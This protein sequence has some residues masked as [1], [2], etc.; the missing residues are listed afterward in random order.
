MA[1]GGSGT[2]FTTKTPPAFNAKH[3]DYIK[4]K[5]KLKL[6]QSV[7]EAYADTHG[8]LIILRLDDD[9]QDAVVEALGDT[10]LNVETGADLVIEK[11]DTIFEKDKTLSK[12]EIYEA[13]E[14][15]KRPSGMSVSDY[16]N[17]FERRLNKTKAIKMELSNDILAYRLLKSANLPQSTEHLIK[18]T[19]FDLEYGEMKT[20]MKKIFTKGSEKTELL[21]QDIKVESDT[22]YNENEEIFYGRSSAGK[23]KFRG[24]QQRPTNPAQRMENSG[25]KTY[26]SSDHFAGKAYTGT[27]KKHRNRL[28]AQGN[29]TR[30]NNCESINHYYNDCPD[31]KYER[32]K[33][34]RTYYQG[35]DMSSD[36][37]D[38]AREVHHKL[39]LFQD[40][41][42]DPGKLKT[43]VRESMSA[44]VLDCGAPITVCGQ[45]WLSCYLETLS[46][47]DKEKV[48]Y[49]TSTNKFKFGDSSSYA[50]E[51]QA[52]IPAVIG[53]KE[54]RIKTDIINSDI[55]LLLSMSSLIK[56]EANLDFPSGTIKILGQKIPLS[57]T[58]SGHYC[59]PLGKHKQIMTNA[60]RNPNV[61][62]TLNN[63]CNL[64]N[65]EIALKL[66]RQFS[67]CPPEKL[68]KLVRN[69]GKEC[70][71]LV[72]EIRSL[73][74]ACKICKEY[75]K[76]S[77]R[78]VVGLP[79]ATRFGECVAIDLKTYGKVHF[80]HLVD[81]ATRLSAGAIIRN[82]K[83]T[84]VIKELF[85]V[86]ISIY[87]TPEKLLTDNGGEFNNSEMRD[88]CERLN[89]RVK[90]TAAESAWSNGLV[91][92]HHAVIADMI[93]KIM[94]DINCTLEFALMWSLCAKNSLM[95]VNGFSPYQLV[96]SR[97]PS[98]PALL[99]DKPP[100][101][102]EQSQIEMIRENLNVLHAS[103]QAFI[104]SES[105]EKIKRALQHN[106]RRSGDVK[107]FTGDSVYYKRL[108]DRKWHGPA[109]VLGQD[110]QQVLVKHGGV[111]VRVHP[112]RL[113]LE[114]ERYQKPKVP[115]GDEKNKVKSKDKNKSQVI[116]SGDECD[117]EHL[118]SL[119][120]ESD[121]DNRKNNVQS[122]N[123]N[124]FQVTSS[125]EDSDDEYFTRSEEGSDSD[126]YD[127]SEEDEPRDRNPNDYDDR[128]S[129]MSEHSVTENENQQVQNN[130]N[131]Q[132]KNNENQQVQN[133][134]NQQVQN[135]EN[136]QVQNAENQQFD[137]RNDND[138]NH[139]GEDLTPKSIKNKLTLKK[140]M[141]VEYKLKNQ[142]QIH[143]GE[144]Y[145]RAGK[146]GGKYS[147]EWNVMKDGKNEVVNFDDAADLKLL[148]K[149]QW[150]HYL[151]QEYDTH[152]STS[153]DSEEDDKC[154]SETEDVFFNQTLITQS[155]N[156][157]LLAK[158]RELKSWRDN[159]VYTE[160]NR[161]SQKL[162]SVK[163]LIKPKLIDG[164]HSIKARLVAKGY[165][166]EQ[167]FR[168]DSPTCQ[169]PSIRLTLS[170]ISSYK[171]KLH[172]LDYKTAYLQGNPIKRVIYINPPKEANT[173]KIWKLN[174]TV[175][176]L[177]DAPREWY[178]RLREVLLAAGCKI[179]VSDSGLFFFRTSVLEGVIVTYV[180]D[181]VWGG[182]EKFAK[183][184][185][186]K[187]VNTFSISSENSTAFQ[188]IGINT[189][190]KKNMSIQIDQNHY[191]ASLKDIA[192]SESRRQQKHEPLTSL[193]QS[194]LKSM[195][196]KANWLATMTRP[197]I[198]F[199]VCF[200]GSS[201]EDATV[202]NI[203]CM[204]K[205]IRH[206]KATPVSIL[207]PNLDMKNIYLVVYSDASYKNLAKGGSQGAYIIFLS[208]G[209]RCCPIHWS[210]TRI[211]RV[212]KSTL[213][214]ETLA[215][216]E[217]CDTAFMLSKMISEIIGK[218]IEIKCIT[219]NQSLYETAHTSNTLTDKRL[220]FEI[221]SIREMIDKEEIKLSW[222]PAKEQ[223]SNVLTKTGV[224]GTQ[225]I[226][227]LAKGKF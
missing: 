167:T 39:T 73:S 203:L 135:A 33:T 187:L 54:I 196:G 11:L 35:R 190:Q 109:S 168:S 153:E 220:L 188:Y 80:M 119:E 149:E 56:A 76:P 91:E 49:K 182:T 206:I 40:D 160:I 158:E 218:E 189:K 115:E 183:E 103:R 141:V 14:S 140:G 95:N 37:E 27:K 71:D 17:E 64:S 177:S 26:K 13:F 194:Q 150:T 118:I 104:A 210:S 116:G 67:H 97:N 105:S 18:A 151:G 226:Q 61:K 146:V 47:G 148:D 213:A 98:L 214:A 62:I 192:I 99:T 169:R 227:V 78:P 69:E 60:E 173:E 85:R 7:T 181:Q 102:N 55:P 70:E 28:D 123:K 127:S 43:L 216:G 176:G 53:N 200:I 45:T 222:T 124:Q 15:F 38:L 212:V 36:D 94:A 72:T 110:G 211:K 19:I 178:L 162:M 204:N 224:S 136:Q 198:S 48:I 221:S 112:C 6:W 193:E 50:A 125:E 184:V 134:E 164:N 185:I 179:S 3:D 111:Y 21:S 166:E 58:T 114:N 4:W 41:Y 120:E 52:I 16:L 101:L 107:Y 142:N 68:V 65:K 117:T 171:W 154:Q 1:S 186:K 2:N 128:N 131:Q 195:I 75:R 208:D 79:M 108:N 92:R 137:M 51:K 219:D 225:L 9:T 93:A 130:E 87:G 175:Y 84:T 126:S 170:L 44:A 129:S 139:Q 145:K 122:R 23:K 89:I 82:K 152:L 5:R 147:N 57:Y 96:F 165:E 20:Q 59:L 223:L 24:Y 77:P 205:L 29:I 66:H 42:G 138:D 174:K 156:E 209:S 90:T 81:H 32:K 133:A 30:C 83:P 202:N 217:G 34:N 159:N 144:L 161:G 132:V 74:K 197:D 22:C 121:S 157:I 180:D 163:W 215:L 199:Q 201:Q 10:D 63:T 100:V 172:C 106:I 46:P 113:A 191:A 143:T 8:P 31:L 25:R 86:W 88:L 207:F 12:Y 155:K